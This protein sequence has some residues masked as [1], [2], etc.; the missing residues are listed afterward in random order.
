MSHTVKLRFHGLMYFQ[1]DGNKKCRVGIHT[2]AEHHRISVEIGKEMV[3][4]KDVYVKGKVHVIPS[5][6]IRTVKHLWLYVADADKESELPSSAQ[7]SIVRE[8][9]ESFEKVMNICECYGGVSVE[10]KW[11]E[12]LTPSL[13]IAAGK[14]F[15]RTLT[16]GCKL[17]SE[18]AIANLYFSLLQPADDHLDKLFDETKLAYQLNCPRT[19]AEIIGADITVG[20]NQRLVLAIGDKDGPTSVLFSVRP[21]DE[22][23]I[24]IANLPPGRGLLPKGHEV[25]EYNGEEHNHHPPLTGAIDEQIKALLRHSFH[26]LHYYDAFCG[27]PVRSV[28]LGTTDDLNDKPWLRGVRPDPPCKAIRGNLP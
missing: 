12:V 18:D 15:A 16:D 25:E 22:L 19:L 14:F 6:V 9:D 1:F 8:G 27:N 13:H 21:S 24:F 2:K 20:A 26:F 28:L 7:I 5:D 11:D 4:D 17:V 10:P 3:K 23:A